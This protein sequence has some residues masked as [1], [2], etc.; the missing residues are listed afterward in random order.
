MNMAEVERRAKDMVPT[1]EP[2]IPKDISPS[3]PEL[4]HMLEEDNEE[5]V[6][7]FFL[8]KALAGGSVGRQPP[9]GKANE[10][11]V[12]EAKHIHIYR[13]FLG[14]LRPPTRTCE[15]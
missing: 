6:G 10:A 12:R 3:A 5:A 1:D 7:G 14:G 2:T 8:H 15:T 13:F 9:R 11:G 4:V